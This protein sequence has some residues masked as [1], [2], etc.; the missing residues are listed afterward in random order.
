MVVSFIGLDD[1]SGVSSF[2]S[3]W[4]SPNGMSNEGYCSNSD[5]DLEL[6]C[7]GTMNFEQYSDDGVWLIS[8]INIHDII[9]NG[10]IYYIEGGLLR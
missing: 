9:G 2:Q 1:I 7:S 10:R 3:V 5:G 6:E 4:V 8:Q